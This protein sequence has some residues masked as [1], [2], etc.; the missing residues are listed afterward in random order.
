MLTFHPWISRYFPQTLLGKRVRQPGLYHRV[1]LATGKP[2]DKLLEGTNEY[3][4]SCVRARIDMGGRDVD[5]DWAQIFPNSANFIPIIAHW[6][7]KGNQTYQPMRK[8]EPLHQWKLRD[9]HKSHDPPNMD[10]EMDPEGLSE[11]TWE[12]NGTE[13][14]STRILKEDRMGPFELKLI[15]K[16][17]TLAKQIIYSNNDWRWRKK[18]SSSA[19]KQA[20]TF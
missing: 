7:R 13:K 3:I 8:N 9:G 17:P 5:Q 14:C 18:E 12:Y 15:Q 2:S 11:V 20:H 1:D 6:F 4:H 10:I 19:P 16:D